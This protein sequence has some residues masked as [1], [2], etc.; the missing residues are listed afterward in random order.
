MTLVPWLTHTFRALRHRDYRLYFIG[1]TISFCGTWMQSTAQ[2]WLAYQLT[3]TST[4]P[5]LVTAAG[6]LPPFFFGLWGGGIAD[7]LPKRDLIFCT[8]AISLVLALL[9]AALDLAGVVRPWHLI[10]IAACNGLVTAVDL[11]ARLAFLVDLV[12][13]DDLVNAVALNS[14]LFNVARAAGPAAAGLL[15]EVLPPGACFLLNGVSYVAV[16]V[17]LAQIRAAGA[18]I[19]GADVAG[20]LGA[21]RAAFGYVVSRP[22]LL[23]ALLLAFAVSL[24]GWPFTTLLPRLADHHL[25]VGG[26]GYALLVS[27][28]GC[29]AL[30]GALAVAAF[31]T[32]ERRRPFL[33]AGLV[34]T[35]L[36]LA[37]LSVSDALVP[38]VA[39]CAV[40]GVGL[41][42]FMANAQA[43]VQLGAAEH[44]RG[45]VLGI[46]SM[47]LSGA[48]PLGI[49]LAGLSADVW[50]E[51]LVLRVQAVLC[52]VSALLLVL[53][54]GRRRG[55][56][57]DDP[58]RYDP[59]DRIAQPE[60]P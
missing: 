51:P 11:P 47:G 19:R 4:W 57:E 12:G 60:E 46:W 26:R 33:A 17:A 45:R 48:L 20:R 25:E 39:C 29:G 43:T 16:L 15:L 34:L 41:I 5:A 53:W 9:L 40:A 58:T 44:N 22:G 54:L 10:A 13:R 56:P 30:L 37:G 21:V 2:A 18:P 24:F 32:P 6:M 36:S 23:L 59:G 1:Q 28:M 8:Q 27:G 55:L 31:A 50:G 35:V 7:R 38:A 14:V 49:L 52:A 42:V 3:G